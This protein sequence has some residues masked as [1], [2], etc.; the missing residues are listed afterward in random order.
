MKQITIKG[1][2]YW[3]TETFLA[4]PISQLEDYG[5]GAHTLSALGDRE[6]I[7]IADLWDISFGEIR[8]L[9]MIGHSRTKSVRT[10][11]LN[12]LKDCQSDYD[13]SLEIRTQPNPY[14][15]VRSEW[16]PDVPVSS[17]EEQTE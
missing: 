9:S 2:T 11:V 17:Q 8:S 14:R 16:I 15:R 5:V 1:K 12:R 3:I 13:K 4:T 6:L 7:R 10:A